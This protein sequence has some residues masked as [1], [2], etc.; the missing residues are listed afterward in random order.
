LCAEPQHC[1]CTT[2]FTKRIRGTVTYTDGARVVVRVDELPDGWS[3]WHAG[4]LSVGMSIGGSLRSGCT[5]PPA[6]EVGTEVVVFN[7]Q[8]GTHDWTGCPEYDACLGEC[9][10]HF[11]GTPPPPEYDDC[12]DVC[13]DTACRAYA[14]DAWLNGDLRIAIE[15]DGVLDFGSEPTAPA[16]IPLSEIDSL[17]DFGSLERFEAC[18]ARF[19]PPPSRCL[20]DTP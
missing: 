12:A 2:D 15:S 17:G 6:H 19:P 8:R 11:G 18:G 1:L 16:Q 10:R 7:Y 3:D 13:A 14:M 5:T 4:P 9:G 20:D